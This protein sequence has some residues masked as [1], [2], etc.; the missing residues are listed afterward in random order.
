MQ[1]RPETVENTNP[2]EVDGQVDPFNYPVPGESLTREAGE[3]NFERP[4]EQT[5]PQGVIDDIKA[6]L[7]TPQVADELVAQMGAGFPVEAIVGMLVKGGVAQ[8]K[9]SPDVAEIVKPAITLV[10][11]TMALDQGITDLVVFTDQPVDQLEEEAGVVERMEGTMEQLRPELASE[12]RAMKAEGKIA[13]MADERKGRIAA[14][15]Q[16]RDMDRQIEV[17][18]DGSFLEM[19]EG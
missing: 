11:I 1:V 2:S 9:F 19:E 4:P 7:Q 16:I 18:S 17:P 15:Q 12:M 13:Q 3:G 10:L 5:D 8:G 14:K 6:Y